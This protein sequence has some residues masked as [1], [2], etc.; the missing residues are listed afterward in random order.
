[1]PDG[2]EPEIIESICEILLDLLPDDA[3]AITADVE[4]DKGYSSVELTLRRADGSTVPFGTEAEHD[5]PVDDINELVI[6]LHEV[7]SA[8]GQDPWY[9]AQIVVDGDGKFDVNFSYE[10]PED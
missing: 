6:Q 2:R 4:A 8:D 5:E 3:E 9:G 1:M 10:P 7:M